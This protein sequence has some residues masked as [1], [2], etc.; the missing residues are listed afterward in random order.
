MDMYCSP[1]I[2]RNLVS[3]P[4]L[5][6]LGYKLVLECESYI[7]SKC[8]VYVPHCYLTCNL[9]KLIMK[10][11]DNSVLNVK[12]NFDS[13]MWHNALSHVNFVK[14]ILMSK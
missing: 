11:Y 9:F 10:N 3:E 6:R 1:K 7:I 8:G 14:M 4:T 5:N 2:S 13:H 12:I